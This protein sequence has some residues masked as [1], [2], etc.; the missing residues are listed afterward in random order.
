MLGNV[1]MHTVL[2]ILAYWYP[3][4]CRYTVYMTD[5]LETGYLLKITPVKLQYDNNNCA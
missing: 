1:M 2:F 4:Y 5:V 3:L